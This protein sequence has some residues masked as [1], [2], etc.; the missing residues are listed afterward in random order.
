LT[1]RDNTERPVT[2][3]IGSNILVGRDT[4]RLRAEVANVLAG[5]AKRGAVPPLWDGHAADRIADALEKWW[6]TRF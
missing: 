5:E 2:V 3:E 1:V 6:A 4:D